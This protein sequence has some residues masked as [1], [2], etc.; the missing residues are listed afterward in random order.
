MSSTNTKT[1]T[2]DS[3]QLFATKT[4]LMNIPSI[5]T[6]WMEMSLT[7]NRQLHSSEKGYIK[8]IPELYGW[9]NELNVEEWLLESITWFSLMKSTDEAKIF[10]AHGQIG[11]FNATMD[12][13]I[14]TLCNNNAN[15]IRNDVRST[16]CSSIW[17]TTSTYLTHAR[18]RAWEKAS[19]LFREISRWSTKENS[20]L[21]TTQDP[22]Y[23]LIEKNWN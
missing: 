23:D 3:T 17:S 4:S 19:E 20:N 21:S 10:E 18:P 14:A 5:N 2:N 22:T 6:P 15:T 16:N 7:E 13:K 11:K 1:T 9:D 8:K 12:G